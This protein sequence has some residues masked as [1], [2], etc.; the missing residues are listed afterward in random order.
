MISLLP[1]RARER[2][3]LN[4]HTYTVSLYQ[5]SYRSISISLSRASECTRERPTSSSSDDEEANKR[6]IEKSTETLA[7]LA[8]REA[9]SS[10]HPV[11]SMSSPPP[12]QRVL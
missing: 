5:A 4:N 2:E 8:F 3:P 10:T 11:S 7:T 12:L 1:P 6:K 9:S